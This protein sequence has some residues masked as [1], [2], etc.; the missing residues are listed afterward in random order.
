MLTQREAKLLT[1]HLSKTQIDR[2]GDR[3]REGAI[4]D[5]DLKLLDDYRR[6]FG[7]AYDTVVRIIREQLQLKPTGRP[8][9]STTSLIEKLQRESIRLSQVQDIAGC[10]VVLADVV[11]QERVVASL[12]EL[13][14]KA[15]LMDRRVKPSYGYRAV[16]IMARVSGK[17]IE[18]QVR[19]PL[20]HLWAELSEKF[21]DIID[22]SI[23]YGGGDEQIRQM[24]TQLSALVADFE[25]VEIGIAH[26]P[27]QQI[28]DSE[29]EQSRQKWF[30]LK[31]RI[32]DHLNKMISW[33]ENQKGQ[34]P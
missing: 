29:L 5:S 13:F 14:P 24:L 3:L 12:H 11:E 32:A 31:E 30:R 4:T 27:K 16:H 25:E 22:P 17:L 28:P 10:R 8:A 34:K 15:S 1:V 19:S 33:V 6:S 26:P 21:S 9:K 2:L 23:K 18:I 7:D 20:Q